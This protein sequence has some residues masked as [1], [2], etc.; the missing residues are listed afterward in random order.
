LRA[1]ITATTT[2]SGNAITSVSLADD[3][4]NRKFTFTKGTTFSTTDENVKQTATSTS[5]NY[6]VLFSSTA[7]NT[8]RTEGARKNSN[9]TFN[10]SSGTL[11][12][13][14]FSENGTTLANKYAAKT[15]SHNY[16]GSTSD[17]GPATQVTSTIATPT[18]AADFSIPFHSGVSTGG[19]DLYHNDGISYQ[20][21]IGTSSQLGWAVLSL[22]N[23]IASSGDADA[24]RGYLRLYSGGAYYTQLQST[25]LTVDRV[26]DIPDMDGA[27]LVMNKDSTSYWGIHD[28]DGGTTGW[29]RTTE[30]GFIPSTNKTLVEG[31][32]SSLGTASY[33]FQNAYV[34]D[35]HL[36]QILMHEGSYTGTI[37]QNTLTADRTWTFPKHVSGIIHIEQRANFYDGTTSATSTPWQKVASLTTG[38]ASVDRTATFIVAA[39]Y[40]IDV[41]KKFGIL[42]CH[43]RT[44]GSKVFSSG[45]LIWLYKSP[46]M[47]LSDVV[48]CHKGTSNTTVEI[49][50]K[51]VRRYSGY[52]FTLLDEHDRFGVINGQW[53]LTTNN[54]ETGSASLPS[55]YTSKNSI[56]ASNGTLLATETY[57]GSDNIHTITNAD[58]DWDSFS[59]ILLHIKTGTTSGVGD[60]YITITIPWKDFNDYFDSQTTYGNNGYIPYGLS[61]Y[62]SGIFLLGYYHRGLQIA[63]GTGSWNSSK[64][65]KVIGIV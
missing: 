55:G 2:G 38:A 23:N 18:N 48:M 57:S 9:L 61:Q 50:A 51:S 45:E 21:R 6:E 31:G 59:L 7:D 39:N 65:I 40:S 58:Y 29:I 24:K 32:Q 13:T 62:S 33:A 42:Q 12:A 25:S 8:T 63:L 5:A 10:P 22:G 20:T 37:N 52:T 47:F 54:G 44:N 11:S 46:G 34:A 36:N 15:H 35:V 64:T 43:F 28:G 1:L 56:L 30:S 19:K 17:G 26:I 41:E 49:W 14:V 3:G 53:V 16:A 4:N 27:F 60:N